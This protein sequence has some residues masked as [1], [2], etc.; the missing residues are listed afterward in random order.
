M[1]LEKDSEIAGPYGFFTTDSTEYV[2]TRPNTPRPWEH[3]LSN[4]DYLLVLSQWGGGY[5]VYK[6]MFT[7]TVTRM[8]FASQDSGRFFYLKDAETN[9]V[10]SP[11]IWP[12]NTALSGLEDYRCRYGQGFM[13]WE[14]IHTYLRSKLTSAVALDDCVELY[15]LELENL[16][17]S[18]RIL[19]VFSYL[20]W[21][22]EG[23]PVEPGIPLLSYFDE[24]LD[25]QI[26]EMLLPPQYRAKQTGFLTCDSKILSFDGWRESFLGQPGTISLPAALQRGRCGD[27]DSPITGN[28]CGAIHTRIEIPAGSTTRLHFLV[29]VVD[30]KREIPGILERYLS[31]DLIQQELQRIKNSWTEKLAGFEISGPDGAMCAF[32]NTWLKYQL[33]Q[34]SRWTRWAGHKGYR[35]VL[36]DAAGLRLIDQGRSEKMLMTA[37]GKQRADGHAPRQWSASPWGE[38]DWRDYRD[39]CFWL[40]YGLEKYLKETG[41]IEILSEEVPFVDSK[42]SVPLFEHAHRAVNFLRNNRGEHG[43]CLI[44]QGDWLDSLNAAGK[45]GKG[46]SVWL[47][48]AAC[49]AL[50]EMEQMAIL[51]GKE[52]R[53]QQYREWREELADAVNAAG[54][55]G[56]WYLTAFNDLGEPIG[57]DSCPDGGKIFLNPQS[58]GVLSGTADSERAKQAMTAVE[59]MLSC[60]WGY[61]CF[62]PVYKQFAPNVGRISLWSSEAATSY[63]HAVLFKVVADCLLGEGDRAWQTLR[64]IT[65]AS[66]EI[67]PSES[68]AEPF[69]YTNSFAGPAW[70]YPG[71]SFKGWWTATA[72]W[73]AQAIV[74]WI[75]GA[76]AEYSGLRI[77]PCLPSSWKEARLRRPFRGSI[78]DIHISKPDGIC[79]GQVRL[80]IEG[81][82][83]EGNLIPFSPEAKEYDV[84]CEII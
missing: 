65:P 27:K 37:A 11:T 73:S 7:N 3:L 75:F 58:W 6:S 77:D 61:L 1:S 18:N 34:N 59:E 54:W 12:T 40:V 13:C 9:E 70:P 80:V 74:E 62:T 10:W 21:V 47:T 38:H 57:S 44:G 33:I 42:E 4:E 25:C 41:K 31:G 26:G 52:D 68:G 23:A 76:R 50:R 69:C 56:K 51:A 71:R 15:V 14:M 2:L 48:Q 60:R 39:S 45:G 30:E 16:S 20:E 35:D 79:K 19:D 5:S 81:K 32:A 22:F 24:E 53:S 36:Q 55:D 28:S 64:S 46:E 8:T 84:V 72:S 82:P 78:Y 43:L 29:G 63:C 83:F 17:K 66:G 67:N 49:Y